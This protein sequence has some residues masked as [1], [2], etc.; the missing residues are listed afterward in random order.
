[1]YL[2]IAAYMNY[3]STD[4]RHKNLLVKNEER[5]NKEEFSWRKQVFFLP[6]YLNSPF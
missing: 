5:L 3:E 2:A 1:M 4:I 6:T